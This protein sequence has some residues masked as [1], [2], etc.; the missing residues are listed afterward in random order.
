MTLTRPRRFLLSGAYVTGLADRIHEVRP[1]LDLRQR[2][3]GT[4]TAEDLQ[5][6]EVFIGFRKPAVAG[7]GAVAWV[8][9][10]GAGVDGLIQ[11]EPI[12]AGVLL[13]KSGEDFGPAIGEWCIT[14][15][16]AVNQ[17]LTA[18]QADQ[19]ARLWNRDREPILLR[20]QRAVIVGTGQVGSGIARAFRALGVRVDG[21]SRSGR[22][23]VDFE[24]VAAIPAFAEVV[25]GCHWLILAAPLTAETRGLLGRDR[26]R[27]CGGAYLMNVGRGALADE[28]AIPAAIDA[29][30]LSGAALDV[31]ATEPLPP[32]SP[33]WDH[34]GVTISP[35]ISG[36]STLDA[37]LAGFL[38]TLSQIERGTTP[39]LAV[40]PARGY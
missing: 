10:I 34:P 9:G 14:R 7:W 12:P 2:A 23:A 20:G 11:A 16:L 21:L 13:T 6:A 8:H 38:E 40:D 5:W 25:P 17:F 15:A 24:Q 33:L 18:L 26:M 30:D 28:T 32:D 1:D 31:F 35:H 27:H 3:P 19:Q 29:G 39:R 36:P 4:V 37:T 22:P